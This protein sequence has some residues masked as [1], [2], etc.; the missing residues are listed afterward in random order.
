MINQSLV[1]LDAVGVRGE[2]SEPD[3]RRRNGKR[4]SEA[5]DAV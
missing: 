4:Q 1:D 2:I 3:R 5:R